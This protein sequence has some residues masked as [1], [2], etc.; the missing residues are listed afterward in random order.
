MDLAK[1]K[2]LVDA[3]VSWFD[4]KVKPSITDSRRR[5]DMKLK[6]EKERIN[7]ELSAL[8]STKSAAASDRFVERLALE[9]FQSPD[10]ISFTA[11]VTRP[12]VPGQPSPDQLTS[13]LTQDF[14]YRAENTFDFFTWHQASALA[15]VVDGIE[16]AMVRWGKK[17]YK[18]KIPKY[19]TIGDDGSKTEITKDVYDQ[20]SAAMPHRVV[21]EEVEQ[22]VVCED[23]WLIDQLEPGRDVIWDPKVP[24]LDVQKGQFVNVMLDRTLDDVLNLAAAGIIDPITKEDLEGYQRNGSN[25]ASSNGEVNETTGTSRTE[26]VDLQDKNLIRLWYFFYEE[27]NRKYL[28]ISI[29]GKKTLCQPKLVDDVC[30]NGRKVNK[31]PVEVGT[32]KGKLWKNHGRSIPESIAPIEDEWIDHRNNLNDYAKQLLTGRF[33][34]DNPD[35]DIDQLIN[36][37]VVRGREGQDFG[38][39]NSER[40]MVDVLRQTDAINADMGEMLPTGIMNRGRNVAPKGTNATLGAVQ[41]ADMESDAKMGVYIMSRNKTFLKKIL[42]HIAQL[43]IAWETDQTVLAVA[44]KAAGVAPNVVLPGGNRGFNISVIDFNIN[45]QINA[46]L[47]S[48]P[49]YQ[50]AQSLIQLGDWRKANGVPTDF[51][52]IARTMDTLAGFEAGAFDA[53]PQPPAPPQTEYKAV[54]NIDLTTLLSMAPEAGQFLM[55]KMITGEMKVEAKVSDKAQGNLNLAQQNGGGM[56]MANRTGQVVDG[57]DQAAMAM[58]QGGMQSPEGI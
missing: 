50:K 41:M 6:D 10:S 21:T 28:Q 11:K 37:P 49:R 45:V 44:G 48:A 34:V 2:K 3:A 57:T 39:I 52:K 16:A 38:Q 22:E 9:L 42:W 12:E 19:F 35:I 15:G 5:Y 13:L 43:T 23:T 53:P 58:S 7:R 8:P 32:I 24:F 1:Q 47:G 18:E 40:G 36:Q 56:M 30:Y 4:Q 14:I 33:W 31:Y 20:V 51:G 29:E 26:D 54:V 46:G 25:D 17:S 55:N 27:G